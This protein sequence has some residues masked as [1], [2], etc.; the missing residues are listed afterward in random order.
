AVIGNAGLLAET[1][2]SPDDEELVAGIQRA[3]L[4]GRELT[5]RLQGFVQLGPAVPDAVAMGPWAGDARRLLTPLTPERI[6]LRCTAEPD[7]VAWVD[8]THLSVLV[9]NLFLNARD[10]TSGRGEVR[11][12]A[13]VPPADRP[14]ALGVPAGAWVRLDVTDDGHGMTPRDMARASE[15]FYTTRPPGLGVGLGLVTVASVVRAA[16]GHV[17]F[18]SAPGRGTTVSVFLPRA[19]PSRGQPDQ[20]SSTRTVPFSTAWPGTT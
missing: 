13:S 15:P 16:N 6:S 19:T 2:R 9:V 11:L 5:G 14:P 18:A 7:A 12:H 10:A 3:A 20:S 8:R 4:R 1:A 17:A